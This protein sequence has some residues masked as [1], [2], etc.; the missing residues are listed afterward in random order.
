MKKHRWIIFG[1]SLFLFSLIAFL[2]SLNMTTT[3]D[4]DI[5]KVIIFSKNNVFTSGLKMVTFFGGEYA[6][7]MIIVLLL[8]L[9]KNKKYGF[10]V[11][12]NGT[13]IIL[14]NYIIKHIFMRDRPTDLMIIKENGYSFPS[15][16]SMIAVGFY[17]LLIYLLWKSKV[18][19]KI[20]IVLTIII[21]IIIIL[22][23]IS[24]IYLGVHFPTDVLAG[25]CLSLSFL[26]LFV[27]VLERNDFL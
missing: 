18:N 7:L 16:H 19:K 23:G 11:F 10:C 3:F 17:G 26:I 24:R 2:V 13:L 14:L 1:F 21:C 20:K 15:G 12:L 9:I 5:Y 27:Y 25:Y 8:I 6:I 4:L 22:I